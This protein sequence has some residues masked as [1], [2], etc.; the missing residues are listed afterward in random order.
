MLFG[1][2]CNART[3]EGCLQVCK[4][5]NETDKENKNNLKAEVKINK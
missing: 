3:K 5:Y 4:I 1:N 2:V